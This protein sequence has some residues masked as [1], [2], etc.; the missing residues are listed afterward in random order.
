M[1]NLQIVPRLK[2]LEDLSCNL[3]QGKGY[4][5][6]HFEWTSFIFIVEGRLQQVVAFDASYYV[7]RPNH[8]FYKSFMFFIL[9]YHV[10]ISFLKVLKEKMNITRG[11]KILWEHVSEDEK[12]RAGRF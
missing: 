6:H 10:H 5:L 9:T 4:E 7:E 11:S 3:E 12:S 1:E 2:K 8:L